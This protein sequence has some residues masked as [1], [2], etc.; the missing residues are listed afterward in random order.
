MNLH[1]PYRLGYDIRQLTLGRLLADKAE[2][3]G[4]KV[5][6]TWLPDGRQ[7]TYRDLHAASLRL[8]GGLRRH[9]VMPGMHVAVLT[10]NRP[11]AI[12][13]YCALAMLGAVYVPVNTS[14]RGDLLRYLLE[15]S[16][17]EMLVAEN[18]HLPNV[19]AIHASL[20]R[21][22]G[23]VTLDGPVKSARWETSADYADLIAGEPAVLDLERPR[24]SDLSA[25]FYTSGTTGPS[26]GVM[27]SHART[28]VWGMSHIE[29]FGYRADDVCYVC[30]P[31][32]H[33]NALLGATYMALVA[34]ASVAL[35]RKFSAS[36]FWRDVR[37]SKATVSSLLGSMTNILWGQPPDPADAKSTLRISQVTPIPEFARGFEARFGVRFASSYGLTD[38]GASHAFRP[39][40]PDDK[41]GSCG[42]TRRGYEAR[43]VDDDEFD[44]APGEVGELILRCNNPWEVSPGYY[45]MPQA[46]LDAMRGGWFHTGDR[47]TIDAEG[48]FWFVDRKKDSIRRRG[49]NISAYEIEQVVLRHPAV[50]D[51]AAFAVASPLGEDDVALAVVLRPGA[52]LT[53]Q[54]LIAH[55]SAGMGRHMVPRYLQFLADLPRNASQ[56]VEKTRLRE[57]A[58]HDPAKL[59]DRERA[60]SGAKGDI[61]G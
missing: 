17:A 56:K 53:E 26:K 34:D 23:L 2:K 42:R 43:I 5:F 46:T 58:E 8:A 55:C 15:H 32:F 48:Y 19:E 31:L 50:A 16:D 27:F 24:F 11:E 7:F 29:A 9:G 36:G 18:E 61:K 49:E 52:T 41:L 44:V 14:A 22:R 25:I 39:D 10:D 3:N 4:D 21:L 51:A 20:P 35:Q 60:G 59:W 30:L 33:V 38:Y 45:K 54:D 47:G 12:F 13:T 6:L 57:W 40:E 28:L 1:S 37:A